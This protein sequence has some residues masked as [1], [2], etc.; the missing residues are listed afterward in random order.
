MTDVTLGSR[1]RRTAG[2]LVQRK[3]DD[4]AVLTRPAGG[5]FELNDTALALWELCD[6]STTVHEMV[7]AAEE[8]FAA[9]QV[10]LQ[11]EVLAA[12]A[13]LAGDGL[14]STA[15]SEPA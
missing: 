7:T 15:E 14:I 4:L 11:C 12:L 10:S 2:V 5:T 9:P 3:R 1:P 8:L 6:G 13:E